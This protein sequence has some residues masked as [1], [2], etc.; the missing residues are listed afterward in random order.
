MF[1][2]L[3]LNVYTVIAKTSFSLSARV[4]NNDIIH[5]LCYI[6]KLVVVTVTIGRIYE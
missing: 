3:R 1:P 5:T 6:L 2:A 4:K